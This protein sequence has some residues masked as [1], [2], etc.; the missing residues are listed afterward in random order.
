MTGLEQ[1]LQGIFE[2]RKKEYQAIFNNGEGLQ[3][4]AD[5]AKN[6]SRINEEFIDEMIA[7]ANA[8][9][10]RNSSASKDETQ[11]TIKKFIPKFIRVMLNPFD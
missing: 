9:L 11:D 2:K 7:A 1:V 10:E 8:H 3:V 6:F 4:K 5:N